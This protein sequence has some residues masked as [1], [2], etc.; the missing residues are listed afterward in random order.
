MSQTS[1]LI[2]SFAALLWP[3]AFIA[4]LWLLGP[5][6][7]ELLA[8]L[9]E[10]RFTIDVGG[11][12]VTFEDAAEQQR[13]LIADLQEAVLRLDRRTASR[14][15]EVAEPRVAYNDHQGVP[16]SVLWVDDYPTNNAQ[17]AASLREKGIEVILATSTKEALHRLR[18]RTVDVVISDMGRNEDGTPM[19]D[20]GVK[21]TELIRSENT[22]IPIYIFCSHRGV[23]AH[24][25]AARKAGATA[26]TSS[27]LELL[28]SLGLSGD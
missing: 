12:K 16:R 15:A 27:A 9:R 23:I 13:K 8:R 1:E 6:V 3:I 18:S 25:A 26:V 5:T 11:V 17:L 2:S 24:E 4:V 28:A 7:R 10:R 21:L 14:Q 22:Q 19:P 20:A